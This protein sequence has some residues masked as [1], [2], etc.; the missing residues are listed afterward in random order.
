MYFKGKDVPKDLDKGL[1]LLHKACQGGSASECD[2]LGGYYATGKHG[3]TVDLEKAYRAQRRACEL[4]HDYCE[5][6]AKYAQAAGKDAA[7]FELAQRG[8]NNGSDEACRVLGDIYK[9]GK[10]TAADE[11]KATAAWQKGCKGG[12]GDED[13][14]KRIGV[15]MKD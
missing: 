13:A 14:C 5:D 2:D 15:K 11:A 4:D 6:A 9:A 7:G 3:I 1:S 12:D 8:C 10:G